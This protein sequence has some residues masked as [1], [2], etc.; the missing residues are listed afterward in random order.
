MNQFSTQW[1]PRRLSKLVE[2]QNLKSTIGHLVDLGEFDRLSQEVFERVRPELIKDHYSWFIVIEP[3]S[4]DY[5][6]NQDELTAIHQAKEKHP[7]AIFFIFC[8]NETGIAG[9]I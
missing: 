6:L 3:N 9:Q 1:S 4:K 7:D 5:F 2:Q 8:V